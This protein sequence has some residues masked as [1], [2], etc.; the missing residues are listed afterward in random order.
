MEARNLRNYW[1]YSPH[2]FYRLHPHYCVRLEHRTHQN[3]FRQ[4][5]D[6]LHTAGIRVILDVVFNHTAEGGTDGPII[7]LKG[8]ANDVFYILDPADRRR[9]QD[10]SGAV[11]LSIAT[12]LS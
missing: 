10:F 3:E 6:A 5:V 7:S 11:T 4:L 1:G 8:F 9:Y 2:S 12:I